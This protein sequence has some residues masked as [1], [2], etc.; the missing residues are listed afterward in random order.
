M[1]T[2]SSVPAQPRPPHE[3]HLGLATGVIRTIEGRTEAGSELPAELRADV[4]LLGDLLG[5]VLAE[6][7]GGDLLADVEQLRTLTIRAFDGGP[8]AFDE[9]E[10]L[11]ESFTIARAD[12]VA[13][14]FT[15]YF[16]LVNLA[17]EH[18]RVRVLRQRDTRILPQEDTIAKAIATLTREV[19]GDTATERVDALR[20]HPVFTAHPTEARRRAVS[21]SIRRISE[22]LA[23]CE[24]ALTG[25]SA[26]GH[27]R[28]LLEEIDTLWRTAPLRAEKPAPVD[29]VRTVMAVFDETLFTVIP[30]VYRRLDEAL[31]GGNSGRTAPVARSFIRV[32]SWIGGDRDG[33]PFVTAKVTRRAA[34]IASDHVLRGL[35]RAASRIGRSLTLGT[36]TTPLD[37][38]AQ[39]LLNSMAAADE[40]AAADIEKRSPGEPHR[41]LLLLIA[42]RIDATRTRNADLAYGDP[43]TLLHDLR[44]LQ[45]SL[46]QAGAA[47]HAFGE[48][49]HLI[50]QVETFG[51]HLT[52]LEVRQHS[53]VHATVLEELGRGEASSD[54]AI[55][56]L[57]VFRAIAFVQH[58]HGP[59]AAGRYIVSFT[60]SADDLAAVY[61]LAEHAATGAVPGPVLD[62]IPLFETFA[63]LQAAPRILDEMLAMPEVAKRLAQTG[64]RVEVMLGYS[65][66]SK[67]VGPVAA[68][69]A[70]YEAQ[71]K[72]A[73]WARENDIALTL[74]HGRGG[75]LGRGGGPANVAILA[76]PPHSVDGR[77]KLTEQGEVIFARY[78]DPDIARRHIE[79]VASAT[80]LASAPSTEERNASAARDFAQMA[81]TMD[82]ASRVRFFELVHAEG[83]APWFATV[84][85]M[86]E[87]GLLALGSRPARRGLSVES[88]EDLRAI[89]WV[90]AWTQARV[91]LT[92]WFGLGSALEAVG[93][94]EQLRTAYARWP[95]FRT[96]VDNVA[97][98]LAK[99]DSRIARRYLA[100]G[101]RDDLAELVMQEMSLTRSWVARITGG[102]ELLDDKPVLQRAVKM[103][104]PYVD[105][106]SLMQLRALRGLRGVSAEGRAAA[107][108]AGAA[109]DGGA[110]ASTTQLQRLLLL[111]VNGVAAG[112]QNTG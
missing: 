47:R 29:E 106:L 110:A 76:Q 67:D 42:R 68:T 71:E 112:L 105:A 44:V 37:A 83:F 43:E 56:V 35:E 58:R 75:A 7:G 91:N 4:R 2:S 11:V 13:R 18:H 19:G 103:R 70:L 100:L 53:Q 23:E 25:P 45:A 60:R 80:L 33:N 55:E 21:T 30:Q 3:E 104:S 41:S 38:A 72:I 6:Q 89:P 39:G 82:A 87:V 109:G 99:T 62:V 108:G 94:T 49:Q 95:L 32:G 54:L 97:M 78:G 16:H 64:R 46:L 15:C 93:D 5:R 74:F 48:L 69:L 77:F 14:A 101:D 20:F 12:E 59:R 10:A 107:E 9:A 79:Q 81:A 85:P 96:M 22:I 1:S 65:D 28:R 26:V 57:D 111:T 50:W 84:T 51:F 52:E 92:G 73:A 88:L 102:D 27:R 31:Q 40:A 24:G 63:D 36:D 8:G 90:F 86:E 34:V 61:R 17:E 66:S 98:S